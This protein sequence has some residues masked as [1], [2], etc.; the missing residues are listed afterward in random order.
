MAS[1]LATFT[2][3]VRSAIDVLPKTSV[4]TVGLFGFSSSAY[5]SSVWQRHRLGLG[6]LGAGKV[7]AKQRLMITAGP[8][9][10]LVKPKIVRSFS[11]LSYCQK[12]TC[13]LVQT[14]LIVEESS[15]TS[16]QSVS[17]PALTPIPVQAVEP[18]TVPTPAPVK[19]API[20]PL[21]STP[22]VRAP[23]PPARRTVAST[24]RSSLS[25]PCSPSEIDT[26]V[27][28]P[29][30]TCAPPSNRYYTTV[31]PVY[32]T[33]PSPVTETE[34]VDFLF[35]D[36]G[37]PALKPDAALDDYLEDK[38]MRR[39]YVHPEPWSRPDHYVATWPLA[40]FYVLTSYYFRHTAGSEARW[41]AV[42]RAEKCEEKER[43]ERRQ[44][45]Q[46]RELAKSKTGRFLR[47][48]GA[49]GIIEFGEDVPGL[50]KQEERQGFAAGQAWVPFAEDGSNG[51][52]DDG[53]HKV[54]FVGL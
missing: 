7:V 37:I 40:K 53:K 8:A 45:R 20:I 23:L 41:K 12:L 19:A 47:Q 21:V 10:D 50:G 44:A 5:A 22:I 14:K 35:Y 6:L 29:S 4:S 51:V 2:L 26:A 31:K 17:A 13:S 3:L 49:A 1:H 11:F 54:F 38:P 24:V 15:A 32:V 48:P 46:E 39:E 27:F 34:I 9:H 28:L 18:V 42:L 30:D 36:Q 16:T 43:D 33:V 52:V 25:R